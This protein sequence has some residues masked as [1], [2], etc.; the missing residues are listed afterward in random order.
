[1]ATSAVNRARSARSRVARMSA[2]RVA[3]VVVMRD[4]PYEVHG[5]VPLAEQTIELNA[6]GESWEWR[7]GERFAV[8]E[9]YRLCRCGATETP[10]FCDGSE[11]RIAFDGTETAT[12]AP[13]VE[14]AEAFAGPQLTLTDLGRL[15]ARARFCAAQGNVWNRVGE[16]DDESAEL[17]RRQVAR[18]P[19]GRLALWRSE[20]GG[21]LGDAVEPDLE[22]SIGLVEDP[23]TEISGPI[24]VRG[25]IPVVSADGSPYE[26]RNRVT[27]CRCGASRNKP[28]C[29]GSHIRAGFRARPVHETADR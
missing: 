19:S 6:N 2:G 10:P 26:T 28:F 20:L 22:P 12:H 11:Q 23:A 9:T 15:C 17:A 14:E 21:R 16:P 5:A 8:D 27:L 7:E 18:C 4:G 29:D 24:W 3:R 1:M 25:G 13:Y